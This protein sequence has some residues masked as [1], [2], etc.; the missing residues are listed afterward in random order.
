MHW[1]TEKHKNSVSQCTDHVMSWSNSDS[2]ASDNRWDDRGLIPGR[3]KEYLFKSL[4]PYR[5]RGLPSFISSGYQLHYLR[6]KAQMGHD[7]HRSPLSSSQVVIKQESYHLSP[8]VPML[9]RTTLFYW[10]LDCNVWYCNFVWA[11]FFPVYEY[12]CIIVAVSPGKFTGFIKSIWFGL[13]L[14]FE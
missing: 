4:Y 3:D 11:L 1:K 6:G 10:P 13:C 8:Q 2:V 12:V 7:V 9:N 14:K 5:L